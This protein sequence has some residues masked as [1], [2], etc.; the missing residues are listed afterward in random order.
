M[1]EKIEG[2]KF[3]T[4]Q[5]IQS[6]L[7]EKNLLDVVSGATTRPTDVDELA[8]WTAK[9]RRAIALIGLAISDAYL[10]HIDLSKTSKEMWDNLNILF[11]SKALNAKM[12]LKQK[13]FKLKMME[14]DNIV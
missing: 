5:I 10:H 13:L 8:K 6:I 7:I 14:G 11:G 2:S 3:H 1:I 4:W 12:G 9:D